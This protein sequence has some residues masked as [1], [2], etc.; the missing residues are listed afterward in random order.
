M[1]SLGREVHL[2]YDCAMELEKQLSAFMRPAEEATKPDK[3]TLACSTRAGT[4][5]RELSDRL[6]A[7]RE[8]LQGLLRRLEL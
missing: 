7:A 2:T 3:P 4:G 6:A 5:I 8:Q 1:E